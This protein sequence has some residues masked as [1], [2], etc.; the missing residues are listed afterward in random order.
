[1]KINRRAFLKKMN[2][3]LAGI[4]GMLGFAGCG[5]KESGEVYTVKGTVVDKADG[6]PIKGIRVGYSP[7]KQ[8]STLCGVGSTPYKPKSHVLTNTNGEFTLADNFQDGEY[9]T[10]NNMPILPVFVEDI[11][12]KENGL[13]QSEILQVDFPKGNKTVTV[14]VELAEIKDQ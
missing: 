13:F 8:F 11:D 1:M 6:K 4:I 3:T 5:K 12:G 14:N 9:Q 7:E 10:I 2:W